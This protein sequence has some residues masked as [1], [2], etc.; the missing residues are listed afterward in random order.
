[1]LL[2][3]QICRSIAN[4]EG[5]LASW[6]FKAPKANVMFLLKAKFLLVRCNKVCQIVCA[7]HVSAW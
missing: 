5:R 3:M 6:G 1:M 7:G 2:Q 4:F